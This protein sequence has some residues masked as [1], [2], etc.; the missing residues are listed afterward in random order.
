MM[1]EV[2]DATAFLVPRPVASSVEELLAGATDRRPFF[3]TDSKSGSGFEQVVI[4]GERFIVKYVHVDDDW[5]MRFNGGVGCHPALVWQLG[6]MDVLPDRIDHG[7]VGVATGLGRNGWGAAI[8][9]RDMSDELVPAGDSV[10]PLEQH[11]GYLEDLAALSARM[12][13]WE[14]PF[15]LVPLE[16]RW[17]WFN[18]T[19]LEVEGARGWPD[20]VPRIAF[21]GWQRF[22]ERV[23]RR[24]FELVDELRRDPSPMVVAV[25]RT[26]QTFLHGDWKLGNVGSAHDGRTILIDWTYPGSGPC[27]ADLAWYVAINRSRMPM[28]KDD[29]IACFRRSLER[30]GVAT[31]G[32]FDRQLGI[33][34]LA[35]LVLMGWEKAL[36]DDAEL[37]W[38]CDRAVEG[39]RWL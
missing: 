9:M 4:D 31:D 8:L 25:R 3:N 16:N 10:L 13:G 24:V 20:P 36:G 15:G 12:F 17:S 33:S 39:A 38:W 30:C 27:T 26:P 1:A 29:A 19:S 2:T 34:L 37:A 35:L 32:W 11:V 18:H 14:D 7:V 5:T 21:E 22:A 23:P 6:L 28:S